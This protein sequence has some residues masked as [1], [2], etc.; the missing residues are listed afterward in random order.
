MEAQTQ[1]EN[2]GFWV[3]WSLIHTFTTR[4][5]TVADSAAAV[6]GRRVRELQPAGGRVAGFPRAHR[7]RD[8]HQ[9]R[10]AAQRAAALRALQDRRL[11]AHRRQGHV[12]AVSSN[13]T[14]SSR[15][16]GLSSPCRKI[17]VRIRTGCVVHCAT[18]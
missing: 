3:W 7:R 16:G 9:L 17:Y 5:Q 1:M 2:L 15:G 8:L 18:T 6:L 14:I 13:W 11:R 12:R 10:A 4:R